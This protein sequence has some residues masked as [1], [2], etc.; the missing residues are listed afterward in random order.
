MGK[1]LLNNRTAENHLK[2]INQKPSSREDALVVQR[3]VRGMETISTP[4]QV[5][6]NRLQQATAGDNG[7]PWADI[8]EH[9]LPGQYTFP[10]YWRLTKRVDAVCLKVD[11]L[12]GGKSNE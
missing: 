2:A 9:I 6:E 7:S 12:C 3:G 11:R 10:H 1:F 8:A 5:A 4:K